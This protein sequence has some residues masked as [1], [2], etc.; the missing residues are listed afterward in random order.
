MNNRK[1]LLASLLGLVI[2][3][4]VMATSS[5]LID[6]YNSALID[7][8][9]YP[10]A[11]NEFSGEIQIEIGPTFLTGELEWFDNYGNFPQLVN[12]SFREA[13]YLDHLGKQSW[14]GEF[15]IGYWDSFPLNNSYF[16]QAFLRSLEDDLLVSLEPLLNPGGRL[17]T[18]YTEIIM[19]RFNNE[20]QFEIG[21]KFAVGLTPWT[22][23][24]NRDTAV[25][26]TIVGVLDY[27]KV[28]DLILENYYLQSTPIIRQDTWYGGAPVFMLTSLEKSL[29]L[30]TPIMDGDFEAI[31]IVF[32]KVFI[33]QSVYSVDSISS[34]KERMNA[35]F[36]RLN[37][38]FVAVE[39]NSL[40]IDIIDVYLLLDIFDEVTESVLILQILLLLI[41]IPII[42]ISIYLVSYSYSLIKRQKKETI[43]IL[44]TRGSTW[45]QT[46][47]FLVGE[48]LVVIGVTLISGL[49]L[50]YIVSGTIL[51]SVNFLDF[52]GQ[53][54]PVLVSP[55]LVQLLFLFVV[56]ITI[57]LN[58]SA[59]IQYTRM[60]IQESII[61]VV[62]YSSFW[63]RYYL[64][65]IATLL[66]LAGYLTITELGDTI[67]SGGDSNPLLPIIFLIV[68][69][70]T[71]FFLFFGTI[72]LIARLFP[73][74]IDKIAQILWRRRGKLGAFALRNVVRHR[75]AASQ[76]VILITLAISYTIISGSLTISVDETAKMGYYHYTG[77]DLKVNIVGPYADGV[78][79]NAVKNVTGVSKVT[80][81]F[82]ANS[83]S[84]TGTQYYVFFFVDPDTYA[85]AAFFDESRFGLSSPL[86]T[87]M[88]RIS[89]NQSIILSQK[90][91]ASQP[92]LKI[93]DSFGYHF[94]NES[95]FY[96][97]ATD[98]RNY[99][100]AGSFNHW[101]QFQEYEWAPDGS[102][103][104][105][106]SLGM[107]E[108]LH[109]PEYLGIYDTSVL[110]KL[111]PGSNTQEIV[112]TVKLFSEQTQHTYSAKL[113]YEKYI[114]SAERRFLLAVLN[115]ALT[116]CIIIS[117][118]GSVMFSLFTYLER[119][120]EIGV[121][122]ALGMTRTQ[123]A[124]LFT[125]EGLTIL[126]F[127][128]VIG[129]LV[130]LT[131]TSI[132]LLVI[133]MG[134]TIPP[135]V[136]D[137]PVSF[138]VNFLALVIVIAAIGTVIIAYRST[139]KDISRVL[140]VE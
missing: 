90:N 121:E 78:V 6:S 80:Q 118:L 104:A 42:A 4:T 124:K 135:I 55:S 97:D 87:L 23:R 103:F 88:E 68:G 19:V 49:I 17:P 126:L 62:G 137:Y 76:A 30:M 16:R 5:M 13:E 41:D 128:L 32:G 71:P 86:P 15:Y 14:F 108:S 119:G 130:G 37:E 24:L 120:K 9:L 133:Q 100:I 63:K 132:F 114:E 107:W 65:I 43:G 56:L 131:N 111:E 46:V 94:Y 101:P 52:S 109:L 10:D 53:E 93:N 125:M 123:T 40:T 25:N 38:N 138:I 7:E 8:F 82:L 33:D 127:G 21:Q 27:D 115:T 84:E 64:D 61:P 34:E 69:V 44:K 81:T 73:I 26:T 70:P 2:A 72:L 60:T 83:P 47:F 50:G 85:E 57:I 66:G 113:D 11:R 28:E 102:I 31:S 136:V 117:V 116:A 77:A 29:E 140:K 112:E 106:G 79:L 105:V 35:L 129:V 3:T 110:A 99:T 48:S 59:I 134:R 89:D 96:Q 74:F 22:N 92:N 36:L 51:R 45:Q 75:E 98:Y 91:I 58:L 67:G 18:N 39:N 12:E 95:L 122:R 139:K 1:A 20:T 54:I